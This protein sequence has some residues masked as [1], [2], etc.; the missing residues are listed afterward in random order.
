M[1]QLKY[2]P[3]DACPDGRTVIRIAGIVTFG[4]A[5]QLAKRVHAR[6]GLTAHC[7]AASNG[8]AI[9]EVAVPLG[10]KIEQFAQKAIAEIGQAVHEADAIAA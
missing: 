2:I 4:S 1:N 5:S 8:N 10:Q 9:V 6:I 7:K 3:I